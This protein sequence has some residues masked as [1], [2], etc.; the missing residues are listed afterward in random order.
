MTEKEKYEKVWNMPAYRSACH[1]FQLWRTH[2]HLFPKNMKSA[3]DIGCGLGV[4][5]D[6]LNDAGIDAHGVDIATNCLDKT[7]AQKYS[8]KFHECNIWEMQFDHTFDFGICTDVMEH[9]PIEYVQASVDT[10]AE[11]CKEVLFK[12]AHVPSHPWLGKENP[13]HLT[14]KPLEW[15]EDMLKKS[16]RVEFLGTVGRSGFQDSLIRWT[17]R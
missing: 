8:H 14:V 16:G 1:S 3:L 10:I 7:I 5:I 17:L 11:Y 4:L 12:I 6:V 15:W 2:R 13:L 9:I